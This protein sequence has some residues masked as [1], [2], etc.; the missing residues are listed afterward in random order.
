MARI[1]R[2]LRNIKKLILLFNAVP[3]TVLLYI[4]CNFRVML[5]F[6][7]KNK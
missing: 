6:M 7:W 4:F 3:I 5:N 2:L 1:T